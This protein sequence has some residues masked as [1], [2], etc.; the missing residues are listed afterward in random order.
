[1]AKTTNKSVT[2]NKAL[3]KLK[4]KAKGAWNRSRKKEPKAAMGN[5][6]PNV[7]GGVARFSSYKIDLDKKGDPYVVL[8]G[9]A[10]EPE[11]VQGKRVSKTHFIKAGKETTVEDKLDKLCSDLQLISGESLDEV[12]LDAISEFL[13]SLAKDKPYY[14]FNTWLGRA[15]KAF[16]NPQVQINIEG[17]VE[18]EGEEPEEEEE[19]EEVDED[20]DDEEED[21][22]EEET[23]KRT[24]KPVKKA[25][26]KSSA[27]GGKKPPKKKTAKAEE[28]DEP[29][30]EE[31]EDEE[32]V[33]NDEDEEGEEA[34]LPAKGDIY[35]FKPKGKK[36]AIEV[37]VV[38]V[39]EDESTVK[40]KE[41]EG[42]RLHP[43]VPFD[44]LMVAD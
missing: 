33:D 40:V 36:E 8:T 31:E 43:D 5:L 30:D 27:S 16:P 4:A 13:D 32:D 15:T 28:E 21:E 41:V 23:P 42:G 3:L 39:N 19:E 24:K 34:S 26:A 11:N 22:E 25:A 35:L 38:L 20:T 2:S 12:D 18:W 7:Q 29:E 6:P 10:L 17:P 1:M 14:G 37:K 9:I 44:K